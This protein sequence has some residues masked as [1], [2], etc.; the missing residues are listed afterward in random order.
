MIFFGLQKNN[1]KKYIYYKIYQ[2]KRNN[3]LILKIKMFALIVKNKLFVF[4][5]NRFCDQFFEIN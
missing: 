5:R 3:L 1:F 2:W 4:S